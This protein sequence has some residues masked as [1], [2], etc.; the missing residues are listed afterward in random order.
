MNTPEAGWLWVP[1]RVWSPAWV[2]WR[3]DDDYVSW[4]P[5]PPSDYIG[6]GNMDDP[7]IDDDDYMIVQR[8]HFIEPD[9]YS[10]IIR[11]MMT[12][13]GLRLGF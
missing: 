5:L 11:I 8:D 10:T 7:Q 9:I 3:Q 12:A 4:A 1:G 13:A 2:N 6:D